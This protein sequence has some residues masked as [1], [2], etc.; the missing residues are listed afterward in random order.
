MKTVSKAL[1]IVSILAE[2][3][4]DL[5]LGVLANRS[6]LD[7]ATVRR[8]LLALCDHGIVE[9]NPK[10]RAYGIGPAVLQLARRRESARPLLKVVEPVVMEV[11]KKVGETTHF[12][13]LSQG[14]LSVLC[15]AESNQPTRV[16]IG[17]GSRLPLHTS[18]A[19]IAYLAAADDS[20]VEKVL[21]G[22]LEGNTQR[23]LTSKPEILAAIE[24]ARLNGFASTDQIS[25]DDV[26]GVATAVIA[27]DGLLLGSLAIATPSH[28]F[29]ANKEKQNAE[30]LLKA[31]EVLRQQL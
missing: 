14:E 26:C 1:R 12:S 11:S 8:M 16:H 27:G 15:S 3:N 31:A 21:G 6:Q 13:T 2:E 23:S 7:K 18:G 22:V 29:D 19:G 10:T 4:V 24:T 5:Q 25:E 30:A 28:R 17:E 9:Q 20:F